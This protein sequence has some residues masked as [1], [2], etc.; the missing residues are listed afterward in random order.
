MTA[1][2]DQPPREAGAKEGTTTSVGWPGLPSHPAGAPVRP[3]DDVTDGATSRAGDGA[4][5][6]RAP[7]LR[8]SPLPASAEALE[9]ARDRKSVV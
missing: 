9:L 1:G 5:V 4:E 7:A 3:A 6:V 8:E 2:P